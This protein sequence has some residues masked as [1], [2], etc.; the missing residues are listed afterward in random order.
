MS[1]VN[2]YIDYSNIKEDLT[3]SIHRLFYSI[4]NI[5]GRKDKWLKM[6]EKKNYTNKDLKV[7]KDKIL[8]VKK[9]TPQLFKYF[10]C[11]ESDNKK[12]TEYVA[13][14]I[15]KIEN[16]IS[17]FKYYFEELYKIDSCKFH[18]KCF[19]KISQIEQKIMKKTN[20]L[21]CIVAQF[22]QNEVEYKT[23][24]ESKKNNKKNI[25]EKFKNFKE[26]FKEG[27]KDFKVIFIV[28][29]FILCLISFISFVML[30]K[31]IFLIASVC[32][33]VLPFFYEIKNEFL[34]MFLIILNICLSLLH[35]FISIILKIFVNSWLYLFKRKII[36]LPSFYIP[37]GWVELKDK[38]SW[39]KWALNSLK[40]LL[41]L[42]FI[43]I[44]MTPF[45]LIEFGYFFVGENAKIV[46][47]LLAIFVAILGIS[48]IM[49]L[50]FKEFIMRDKENYKKSF[51]IIL[52]MISFVSL[53]IAIIS[54][55]G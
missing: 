10:S 6:V 22:E 14:N 40:C 5:Y 45:F 42:L 39:T 36:Y 2:S 24:K 26:K 17:R 16:S 50:E 13:E 7:V 32:S 19:I 11:F 27:E 43:G 52:Y 28:A 8:G 37:I 53:F 15:C 34:S 25:N 20:E 1:K 35:L 29:S 18:L 38:Y 41:A 44:G 48:Y 30:G 4:I 9:E 46:F 47:E 55:K 12:F 49:N 31:E 23:F 51:N 33:I 21:K 3:N 54:L